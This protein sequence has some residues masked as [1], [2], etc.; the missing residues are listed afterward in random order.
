MGEKKNIKIVVNDPILTRYF[1]KAPINLIDA[2]ARSGLIDPWTNVKRGNLSVIGFEPD[3]EE[4]DSLLKLDQKNVKYF[5]WALWSRK[6]KLNLYVAHEP[7]TSSMFP[8]NLEIL[9]NFS[10]WAYSCRTTKSVIQVDCISIDEIV[11]K[12]KLDVDFIKIDTH[13][14]EYEILLGANSTLDKVVGLQVEVWTKE[15]HKGQKLLGDVVKYLEDKNFRVFE[16]QPFGKWYRDT[17]KKIVQE[18]E[19]ELVI[20]DVLLFKE[21]LF[22]N[23]QDDFIKTIKLACIAELYGYPQYSIFLINKLMSSCSDVEELKQMKEII[24]NNWSVRN[25]KISWKRFLKKVIEDLF[26]IEIYKKYSK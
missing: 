16:I 11:D 6:E 18:C 21:P 13:G 3:K 1:E 17:K 5:P 7:S 15:I 2:G 24:V 20:C 10:A 9:E 25:D 12:E 22:D 26:N 19:S 23:T 14:A 4:Y 8:A